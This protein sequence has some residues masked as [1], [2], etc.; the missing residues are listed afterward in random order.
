MA[1]HDGRYAVVV[2]GRTDRPVFQS[3]ELRQA[4]AL[5]RS[6]AADPAV[7]HRSVRDQLRSETVIAARYRAGHDQEGNHHDR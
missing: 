2:N 4:F 5:W 1:E 3:H 7:R 6:L